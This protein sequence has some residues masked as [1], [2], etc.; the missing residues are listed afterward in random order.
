MEAKMDVRLFISHFFA[1]RERTCHKAIILSTFRAQTYLLL[2]DVLF[3]AVI[4]PY[5]GFQCGE[6]S[7]NKWIH[8]IMTPLYTVIT[9][10]RI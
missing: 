2:S 8:I 10:I 1:I 3:D 9:C 6:N 4:Q 5:C 7:S